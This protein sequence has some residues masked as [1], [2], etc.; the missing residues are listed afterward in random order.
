[1]LGGMKKM[2]TLVVA[3]V[4]TIAGRFA[5]DRL[6]PLVVRSLESVLPNDLVG[7]DGW[8]LD[9]REAKGVFDRTRAL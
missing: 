7:P 2:L 6:I 8:L 5:L 3:A 1:M 9:T 4:S